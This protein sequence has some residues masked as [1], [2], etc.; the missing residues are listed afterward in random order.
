MPTLVGLAKW[1]PSFSSPWPQVVL[2]AC[3]LPYAW[4]TLRRSRENVVKSTWRTAIARG[5]KRSTTMETGIGIFTSISV[6]TLSTGALKVSKAT[7]VITPTRLVQHCNKQRPSSMVSPFPHVTRCILLV[8]TTA[9]TKPINAAILRLR[10]LRVP[11]SV[12]ERSGV[13]K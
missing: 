2:L 5:A 12:A 10:T 3:T 1:T 7:F 8:F 9:P 4:L 6:Q 13:P 11:R